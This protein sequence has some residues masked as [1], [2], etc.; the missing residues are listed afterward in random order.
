MGPSACGEKEHMKS[1]EGARKRVQ[2]QLSPCDSVSTAGE[3]GRGCG[4]CGAA[5][6]GRREE[7]EA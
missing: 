7:Q 5:A 6:L 3:E 4:T 1:R 2:S